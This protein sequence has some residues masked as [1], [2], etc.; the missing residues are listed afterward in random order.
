MSSLT[1]NI[2]GS[3]LAFVLMIVLVGWAGPNYKVWRSEKAGQAEL[4]QAD[5]NRQIK[6]REAQANLEAQELNKQAE[7]IRAEGVAASIEIIG[8]QLQDNPQYTLHKWVEGLQDGSSE[9][10]YVATEMNLPITEAGRFGGARKP[11]NQ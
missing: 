9:V 8:N 7:I 3:A 6:V 11:P 5:W 10:I 4:A 1:K 2:L